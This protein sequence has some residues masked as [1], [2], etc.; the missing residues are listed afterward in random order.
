[1]LCKNQ[2]KKLCRN[3][4][5][6]GTLFAAG[7]GFYSCSDTYDLDTEQPSNLN[8]I[9][10]YL[11]ERGEF[12]NTLQLIDDLGQKDI[13]SKTGSKT[14]FV[15]NDD[16]FAK[17]FVSNP[18][19]VKKYEDLSLAQKKLL[20]NSAMIDNPYSTS[21]LSTAQGPVKGEVCRRSS[22]LTLYDSVLVVPS[23]SAEADAILP[24]NSRFDEIRS[25]HDSIVLFTDASNAAPMLHFTA[26]YLNSNKIEKTDIDF[27][28]NQPKGTRKDDDVYVNNAKV[29]AGPDGNIGNVFCK[30]G[31]IH[32]VDQVILPLD[33]MAE[34]IR[35]NPN[36]SLY[37][38]IIERF[39]APDDSVSLT[40][41]YNVVKGTDFD[42]VYVKRYFS[43]RSWGSTSTKDVAFAI[44]KNGAS[45]DASLKFDP[46]WNGLVPPVS[47]DRDAMM[48]DM[49][50]MLVPTNKALQAWLDGSD[51]TSGSAK[52]IIDMYGSLDNVPNSVLDDLVRVNQLASFNQ[53]VPSRFED[54]LND[55]NEPLGIKESDVDSVY[56]ACNGVVYLTNRV[57]VPTAYSSVLF[58]AVIDTSKF[59]IIENAISVLDYA[60]YLNSMVSRYIFLL[61]TNKGMF[62]YLDP[63]SFASSTPQI[64]EFGLDPS[65]AAKSRINVSV[66]PAVQN[67][68]GTWVK[69]PEAAKATTTIKGGI[70]NSYIKNR[71][72]NILDNIIVVEEY[73]PG[74]KYYRTK[75]NQYVR[76]EGVNVGDNVYGTLQNEMKSPLAVKQSFRKEN[77]VS[78]V[79]D[80]IAMGTRNSVAMTLAQHPEFSYFLWML[81]NSGAL[82]TSNAKDGWQAGDQ[83]YGNL[84]NIKEKGDVG[85]ED[86]TTKYKASYLL[87][88]YHYTVYA[89]TNDAIDKYVKEHPDFPDS[90]KLLAAEKWDAEFG[91][92]SAEEQSELV[93]RTG[94]CNGD[95][96]KRVQEEMLDF[97]K[98]HI[99]DNS[100]YIDNAGFESGD[101]ETAKTELIPS[102]T[103]NEETGEVTLSGKYSPGRPYKLKVNVTSTSLRVTDVM[104]NTRNVLPGLSNMMA[105]EYWFKGKTTGK[106]V[107]PSDATIDNSSSVV[108]HGIDGVLL[109]DKDQFSYKYKPLTSVSS[110]AKR[111]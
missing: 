55:A 24:H 58:P 15:A 2:T 47:N 22:S 94:C 102:S 88:N 8:S 97:I 14:M 93:S 16:A 75:G 62:S 70:G 57:F 79:V 35:K 77:G 54:V 29:V 105:N 76:V 82:A 42:S 73:T 17:F 80:G 104:G 38:S 50:V 18:W 41:S 64:W 90:V 11:Q 21:M 49:S 25:N 39:A 78:L 66:Y 84:F 28:Y 98:Y 52:E 96:A 44:D 108:V 20:L 101:Y 33:N 86:V 69:D 6:G 37:S 56:L 27:I 87:N 92:L 12:K 48:E 23:K 68:D 34:I 72:T 106:I 45:F 67:E 83:T 32:Q 109:F 19:G 99:Q 4:L 31:F 74:R 81:E 91:D 43:D 111:R 107:T 63:V 36:M 7:F 10:G 65:A 13:L 85:A 5:L 53:A 60:A 89:P 95:S 30:N 103:V 40:R 51:A 59:K 71:L 9:Y 61:P 110:G 46:G 1:M 100:I 26:K 3:F